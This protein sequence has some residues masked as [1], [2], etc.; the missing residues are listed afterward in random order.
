MIEKASSDLHGPRTQSQFYP[1]GQL[2][3]PQGTSDIYEDPS[4]SRQSER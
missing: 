2:N 1:G 4:I 3:R